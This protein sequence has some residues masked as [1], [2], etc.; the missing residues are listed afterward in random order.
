MTANITSQMN[1]V[2]ILRSRFS[3]PFQFVEI[4]NLHVVNFGTL[5]QTG[6][7]LPAVVHV[8]LLSSMTS[9][10]TSS[11]LQGTFSFCKFPPYGS[12]RCGDG[13]LTLIVRNGDNFPWSGPFGVFFYDAMNI[14]DRVVLPVG[15]KSLLRADFRL[16]RW[17]TPPYCLCNATD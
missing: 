3:L 9:S 12:L 6:A 14:I 15:T 2:R 8:T 1:P 10:P 16:R 5:I 4:N 7:A 13:E 17:L 11:G